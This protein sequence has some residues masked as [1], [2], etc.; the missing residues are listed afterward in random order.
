MVENEWP[1]PNEQL[2]QKKQTKKHPTPT[3][4]LELSSTVSLIFYHILHLDPKF[5]SP[6]HFRRE[7]QGQPK[8][9]TE[10]K[11]S[12]EVVQNEARKQKILIFIF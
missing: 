3:P 7:C 9:N 2:K 6:G 11:K 8:Y 12:S 1:K 5:G 10:G 4:N